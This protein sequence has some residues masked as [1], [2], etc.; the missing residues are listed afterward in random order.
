M[1]NA[2]YGALVVSCC[3]MLSVCT[4]SPL[5]A[6]TLSTPGQQSPSAALPQTLEPVVVTGRADDLT[7]IA[8]SA[9]EGR[10][11]QV[12]LETRPFLRPGEVLEVVPG[13]IVTQHSGTGKANQY[14]LRGF[15]L[16]HGTDFSSFVDGVPVNFSTHAH[17]QGYMDLN[18]VIPELIDSVTFRKGPYYADVGDF[19]SA[20]TAAFHLVKTLPEGYAKVGIGQDDYYRVLVAQTP[21]IG[22]GH[23]LYAFEANFYN[24]PWDHHEHVRK[25]N[26][27]L[28]Y[29][30]TSGPST[31]S[32][33]FAAYS[34][35]WD[36]TDQ[37]PQRA[38]DQGVISRLGAIDPSD[39]GR[40]Q[41]F[42]LYSEW[43]YQGDKSLT[44]A[45][46][47]LT[48]YR[49]HLFSN[50]TFSLD[51][52]V[53]G[54]QFEQSDKRVVA[55]GQVSQTWYTTW[56]K[57][58][59]DHTLGLQVRHDAIP[60]V[61]LFQTL[62]R[63]RIGTTRNDDVHETSVGFYYQNQTQWHP[64][65]RSVLGVRGD[66]F[67][68]DVNSDIPVNSGNKTDAIFSP[69]LSL[70]FGPWAKTEVY[71]NG[72][73]GFHSNDARGTTIT[74]DPKT[75]DP[76]QRVA[77]LVR[78]KGAE[79]GVRSTWIP[80]L[81]STLAFWYLTLNSELVFVGDA[82]ITEPN[83]A[84]RRY[85]IEWSNFYK[86]LPWLSLDFD[87]AHSHARFTEDD[88]AGNY[89]PGSIETTIA[90]GVAI[91]VPN[92]LFGSL[93]TR[94]FGPRPLIE[95]NSVRSKSTTLVNLEAGYKY[96]NLRAQID[97][98]NLLNSHQHDI[99]YFYVSRLPGEPLEGVA[100]I[101]FHP[102]EP[103]TVR[104]YL[105]YRF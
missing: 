70:I 104:F 17:G 22:P 27:V 86:P 5:R 90:T 10:V 2:R 101:H 91:D 103:R 50:F 81:N 73:F 96:K 57:A 45:N 54:D 40:T 47:Y 3:L 99:D 9:S 55:G 15:N 69:K 53:N 85:G 33:G 7:G 52:P 35:N 89:I 97:V 56:L 98:L 41:R 83:R 44:Q 30:L 39:G 48:Y 23:L 80:G 14:F 29:S 18:W 49:L 42:S 24:G 72:G 93:R 92:G 74:V 32:L 20:G 38:V 19:S 78:T 88:P 36:A 94:Y 6:Q 31:F 59:M 95:D 60:E 75:G 26:G 82:G 8:E 105:T 11:G 68:F 79:I 21:Q 87:I 61:A 1:D 37:I 102:V 67:V 4:L 65:V 62:R 77:P 16:D 71:L 34:N 58:A 46:A 43:A 76:A 51:D 12:Q 64:K 25:F 84:S 28:K 100:D 66:V 13:V 63:D